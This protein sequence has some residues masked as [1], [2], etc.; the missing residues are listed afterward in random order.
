MKKILIVEDETFVRFLYKELLSKDYEIEEAI[1]GF[2]ASE[3][4]ES[5][6]YD[7]V[8]LDVNIPFVNGIEL[9]KKIKGKNIKAKIIMISAYGMEEKKEKA[10]ELGAVEYLVKPIDLDVLKSKIEKWCNNDDS[11]HSS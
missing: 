11:K 1:D 7:I 4:I 6:K 8:L 10:R 3:M 2:E 5:N 9:L